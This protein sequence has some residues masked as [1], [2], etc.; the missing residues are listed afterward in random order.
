MPPIN[1]E[2]RQRITE[3]RAKGLPTDAIALLVGLSV[4][5]VCGYERRMGV[6]KRKRGKPANPEIIERN[7][8]I[9]EACQRGYSYE[10]IAELFNVTKDHARMIK[11]R[12]AE[13]RQTMNI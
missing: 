12:E 7:R 4:Q 9:Y 8:M 3:L 1:M 6:I 5:A 13:K 10:R 2:M 11:L